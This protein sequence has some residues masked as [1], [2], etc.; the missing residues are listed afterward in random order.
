MQKEFVRLSH[1]GEN[2]N[3]RTIT[4]DA[5]QSAYLT[6]THFHEYIEI[7][8]PTSGK[9]VCN[10]EGESITIEE[11]QC[12]L[13]NQNVLHNIDIASKTVTFTYLQFNVS[14]FLKNTNTLY[15]HNKDTLKYYFDKNR[16]KL[17]WLFKDILDEFE[18]QADNYEIYIHSSILKI[19]VYMSRFNIITVR[20]LSGNNAEDTVYN[21][22]KYLHKNYNQPLTLDTISA[23][24][25]IS[26]YHLSHIFKNITG[27]T[28]IE[29]LTTIRFSHIEAMLLTTNM[30]I[31]QIA[32]ESGFSS[33][34]HFNKVFKKTKGLSPKQYKQHSLDMINMSQKMQQKDEKK[35]KI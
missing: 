3:I 29:F 16:K 31:S 15:I 4:I 24:F 13:I 9:I 18:N 28:I 35:D 30:S 19:I 20:K 21:V 1:H 10:I 17:S 25:N 6:K 27:A 26:K 2:F 8:M 22:I 5:H 34:Q 7:I 11:G 32:Y 23:E 14:D 12:I 33:I